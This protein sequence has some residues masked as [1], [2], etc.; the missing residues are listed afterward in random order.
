MSKYARRPSLGLVLLAGGKSSRM[1]HDKAALP[2]H[3]TDLLTNRLL[4]SQQYHFAERLISINRPY[5]SSSLPKKLA[6]TVRIIPDNY[7]DCGPL[8]G[9][10]AALHNGCCD[11]YLALSVDLP[12]YDFSPVP[13]L[14]NILRHQ[15]ELLAIIP[16]TENN[17]DQPLAALYSRKL[18]PAITA[19]LQMVITACAAYTRPYRQ[20]TWMNPSGLLYTSTSIHPQLMKPP[21]GAMPIVTAKSRSSP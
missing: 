1:G 15:P 18:L 17:Q 4:C 21:K 7:T 14:L 20:P 13:G 12:F 6:R 10:E 11:F 16:K 5:P 9:M 19:Q 2:W 8:G 3:E